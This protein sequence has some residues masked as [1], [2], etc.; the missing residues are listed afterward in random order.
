MSEAGKSQADRDEDYRAEIEML[1][2]AVV[3]LL[4]IVEA[5]GPTWGDETFESEVHAA[6]VC[7]KQTN[8]FKKAWKAEE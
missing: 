8:T 1:E 6:R 3:M 2:K 4:C 5:Y 7:L